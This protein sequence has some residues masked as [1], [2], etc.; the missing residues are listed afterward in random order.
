M[1]ERGGSSAEKPNRNVR[2]TS[3]VYD[4]IHNGISFG[5]GGTG[6]LWGGQLLPMLK[7]ELSTL[8]APWDTAAFGEELLHNYKI[9]QSWVGVTSSSFSEPLLKQVR[10]E[11]QQL[12]W[13]DITPLFSK[14]IPFRLRNLGSAWSAVLRK[15]GQ[16]RVLLNLQP[17]SWDLSNTGEEQ[18]IEGVLCRSRNGR[19]VKVLA[20]HFV[21]AAGALDSPPLLEQI[22]GQINATKLGVG[23]MLHDHLSLRIA[24]IMNCRHIEFERLFSPF[25]ER[26]TM[27]SLRLCLPDAID[28]QGG[29]PNWAYCHFVIE[30]PDSSG[31]AV[32]RDFLRGLQA[33]DHARV[34]KAFLRVPSA[35]GDIFRMIWMRYIKKKLSISKGSRVFIN[36]DFVQSPN[37]K[38]RIKFIAGKTPETVEIDWTIDENVAGKIDLAL[39]ALDLFWAENQLRT[40]G[41]IEPIASR[42][43]PDDILNNIYDIYHPA[44]TCAIGRVV[45]SD[46]KINGI[47]NGYV[48]GSSVFPRLG[49]SNPTLTIM[50]LSLRLGSF[51]LTRLKNPEAKSNVV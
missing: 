20:T 46:L 21:I 31:F 3:R 1:V 9:I 15:T 11:A 37:A 50:A 18:K 6:A 8:G 12:N 17:I 41:D 34:F 48:V 24:E 25:F 4:G 16:V 29:L 28:H 45:D 22:L 49:R 10:H 2:F 39:A 40:I 27:R 30:A 19:S 33:K 42:N 32:A 14:W 43:N 7:S 5:Y 44:G 51:I 26:E 47:A 36:V 13:G 38:N 23:E 35:L